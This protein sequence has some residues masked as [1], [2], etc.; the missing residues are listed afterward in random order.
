MYCW[1]TP[2]HFLYS[3]SMTPKF[4]SQP[5]IVYSTPGLGHIV[6]DFALYVPLPRYPSDD[7]KQVEKELDEAACTGGLELNPPLIPDRLP[8]KGRKRHQKGAGNPPTSGKDED[9]Q[10]LDALNHPIKVIFELV[11]EKYVRESLE[12]LRSMRS[13]IAN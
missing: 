13:T 1:Q 10:I 7:V 2:T 11:F 12:Y 9:S 5:D 3:N 8:Q 4:E 6:Q